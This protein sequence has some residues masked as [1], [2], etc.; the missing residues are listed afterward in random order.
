[1]LLSDQNGVCLSVGKKVCC[2]VFR[3]PVVG[4]GWCMCFP[5]FCHWCMFQPINSWVVL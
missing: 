5:A 4:S 3:W 1:M 2:R